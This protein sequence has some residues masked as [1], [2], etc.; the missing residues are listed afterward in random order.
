MQPCKSGSRRSQ[1]PLLG[2]AIAMIQLERC[3][4]LLPPVEHVLGN[5]WA[6][7]Q[8][9]KATLA[10]TA[11]RFQAHPTAQEMF[12]VSFSLKEIRTTSVMPASEATRHKKEGALQNWTF[13]YRSTQRQAVSGKRAACSRTDG[14]DSPSHCGQKNERQ[15]KGC[16]GRCGLPH[17]RPL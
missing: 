5:V 10:S 17:P 16:S 15:L 4:Q 14:W 7:Q 3:L 9:D 12:S 6:Q 13:S 8:S 1:C 2:H 11:R